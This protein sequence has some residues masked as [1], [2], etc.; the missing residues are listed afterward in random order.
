M[1]R[2]FP[3]AIIGCSSTSTQ[4][5][6]RETAS[7][8]SRLDETLFNYDANGKPFSGEFMRDYGVAFDQAAEQHCVELG[9][10]EWQ[11]AG[12]NTWGI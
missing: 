2:F 6:P 12:S 5:N 10:L 3:L 1:S 7:N 4:A 9:C 8:G 11:V